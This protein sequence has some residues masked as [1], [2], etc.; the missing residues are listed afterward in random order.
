MATAPDVQS[1]LLYDPRYMEFVEWGC[2]LCEQYARQQL[3]IPD[4][5]TDWKSWGNGLLA[6]DIFTDQGV[7]TTD[8][9]DNWQ[10]WAFAVLHAM[11]ETTAFTG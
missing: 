5:S 6:I 10:D 9:Y 4:A 11:N 2:L 7:P 3:A 8:N 1:P